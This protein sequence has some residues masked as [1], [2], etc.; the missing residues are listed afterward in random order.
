MVGPMPCAGSRCP[1]GSTTGGK[2]RWEGASRS[3]G[4]GTVRSPVGK[5]GAVKPPV[6]TGVTGGIIESLTSTPRPNAA[7]AL[8][9]TGPSV[10]ARD[11]PPGSSD[12]V[13]LAKRARFADPMAK[14]AT[15]AYNEND[16]R[17]VEASD[18][19]RESSPTPK[20]LDPPVTADRLIARIDV[21]IFG[22]RQLPSRQIPEPLET[23][24]SLAE[25][26]EIRAEDLYES[27]QDGS[28]RQRL[29]DAGMDAR[30]GV[31]VNQ[32]L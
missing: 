27:L 23:V 14:M 19:A 5:P 28:F 21:P 10:G 31:L 32:Y 1:P 30:M 6:G 29:A 3:V 20:A 12:S 25:K 7:G 11:G 26:L 18:A 9:A 15:G 2:D 16:D 22:A 13:E 8:T 4:S 17:K 24:E